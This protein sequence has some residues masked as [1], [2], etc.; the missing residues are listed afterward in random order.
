M[1]GA[2]VYFL[3]TLA[4]EAN[5]SDPCP[6]FLVPSVPNWARRLLGASLRAMQES[7]GPRAFLQTDT[8]SSPISSMTITGPELTNCTRL[9]LNN[10]KHKCVEMTLAVIITSQ[11]YA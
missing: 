5:E 9:L 6:A 10:K 11:D 4:A 2:Y 3:N 7:V 1:D 8:A